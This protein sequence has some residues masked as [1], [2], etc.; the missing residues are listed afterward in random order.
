MKPNNRQKRKGSVPNIPHLPPVPRPRSK[1]A[2]TQTGQVKRVW[3]GKLWVHSNEG[4]HSEPNLVCGKDEHAGGI[5]SDVEIE[6]GVSDG[7]IAGRWRI[8]LERIEAL[9][10][11]NAGYATMRPAG[12]G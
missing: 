11:V 9:S 8:T 10:L 6:F 4:G 2:D 12:P 1:K 7:Q 5:A 3:E